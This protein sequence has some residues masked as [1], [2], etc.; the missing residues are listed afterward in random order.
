[1]GCKDEQVVFQ[2]VIQN[3]EETTGKK[4]TEDVDG[5]KD[6]LCAHDFDCESL[7]FEQFGFD[8]QWLGLWC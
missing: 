4:A 2:P 8:D 6:L 3:D 5:L 7:L 1:M